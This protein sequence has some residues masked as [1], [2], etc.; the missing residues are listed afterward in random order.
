MNK[1]YRKPS[2]R[3]YGHPVSVG[4]LIERGTVFTC[5]RCG[6]V[7]EY[8]RSDFANVEEWHTFYVSL[9][10]RTMTHFVNRCQEVFLAQGAPDA[11]PNNLEQTS[12][13]DLLEVVQ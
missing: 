5:E 13:F 12:I 8:P 4:L 3:Y 1:F 11:L 6:L 10:E 7:E 2:K 9:Q